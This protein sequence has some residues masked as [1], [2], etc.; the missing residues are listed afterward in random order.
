MGLDTRQSKTGY[1]R[2]VFSGNGLGAQV[3]HGLELDLNVCEG[4]LVCP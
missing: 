3:Q 4:D 2:N 1:A